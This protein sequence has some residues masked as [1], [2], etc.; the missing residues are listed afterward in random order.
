MKI[1][2]IL[3]VSILLFI[4]AIACVLLATPY[5]FPP[6]DTPDRSN[7]D[8]L[9]TNIKMIL[10]SIVDNT[11]SAAEALSSADS[12]SAP[13]VQPILD[14]LSSGSGYALSYAAIIPNGTII[15]VAPEAYAGSVG[16]N[17]VGNEP[18][19]SI[20]QTQKPF[21]SDAFCAQ[22]GFTGIEIASPVFSDGGEYLGSVLVMAEPSAFVGE[23]VAPVEDGQAITVTVMQPD[24]FILYDRD[25][26][27]VG[28]N[29][30]EDLPFTN[31]QS[32]QALGHNISANAAGS[33]EYTFYS[34]PENIEKL[35]KKY[36]DWDT[37]S[38]LDK[39]W[40]IIIFQNKS[41]K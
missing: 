11:T 9:N 20:I 18:G 30:F 10:S 31:Y 19:N 23:I 32:L 1:R 35:V 17:I 21:L 15:A 29:L 28:K 40:R 5:I 4:A 6:D 33:G 36:A 8:Y 38:F 3:P 16:I 39:E 14:R 34:S 7:L 12:L 2:E 22:E 41:G 26:D 13:E 27:Q 24:G 25:A 37:M